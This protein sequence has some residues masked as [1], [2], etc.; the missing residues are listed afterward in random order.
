MD[1]V[2]VDSLLKVKVETNILKSFWEDPPP[3]NH[4]KI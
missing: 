3:E 4:E 2:S 1:V